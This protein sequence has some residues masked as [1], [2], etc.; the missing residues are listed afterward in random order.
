[1]L[2]ENTVAES[3]IEELVA[4]NQ[5]KAVAERLKSW[6][7]PEIADLLIG[8]E[9]PKQILVYRA[10]PRKR[11]ADMFAHLEPEHQDSLL[12]ALTDADTRSLLADISPDDRTEMLEEL[13]ATVTRRLM[14]LLTPE[15]LAEA[16]QLLGYP[17]ESVGR[18]MTPDY[19][20]LR[21]EWTVEV[22]LAHMRK[23]GRDSEIVNILYVT[24]ESGKLI[25]IVRMRRVIMAAPGTVIRDMLNYNCVSISAF[26]DREVAVEMIQRYDVNALPVVDSEGVLV[27]IVTVDDIMDVAEEEA[28]ED[29]QKGVAVAPLETKYSAATPTQLFR[30]RI[31]W[32]CVLIFVNLIS[33]GVIAGFE[34]Q[35]N[36]V[37]AL[38][39][40]M[41]L[42]IA[43]GGNSGAQSAT[44]MVRAIA[45]GDIELG[46]W[47]RAVG[48]E[49]LVG[50]LLGLG[51]AVIAGGVGLWYGGDMDIALIVGLSMISIVFVANCFG[52]LLPFVLSRIKVD[53]A[54]ASTPLVTSVMDVLGLIIYFS[55]ASVVIS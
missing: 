32:L 55:I 13:P 4:T 41:P 48:K 14:Q 54:A 34:D 6:A 26:E 45:T 11:A 12:E 28:T 23:Y 5:L 37:I 53:P 42:V 29:I 27:G 24:D 17:E 22:A 10:L 38:A 46:E 19:I 52:A 33:A 18:L 2:E 36:K 16:R 43:S 21:A 35:I 15:D 51:M 8:L 47:A 7:D 1:M 25:D 9:K 44:L 40:F 20:R 49:T 3:E 30:K 31:G 39:M 50:V